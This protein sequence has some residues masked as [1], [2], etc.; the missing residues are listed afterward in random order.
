MLPKN[1]KS[2]YTS[3][4]DYSSSSKLTPAAKIKVIGCGG[5]GCNAIRRMIEFGLEG[6]EFWALNT[7]L[8]VLK[9]NSC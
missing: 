8:Q 2:D 5:G 4:N 3:R 9:T 7:D 1:L 6:V